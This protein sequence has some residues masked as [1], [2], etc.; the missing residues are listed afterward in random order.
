M[1]LPDKECHAN[2]SPTQ[3]CWASVMTLERTC[4]KRSSARK[5]E[6]G[7]ADDQQSMMYFPTSICC[8]QFKMHGRFLMSDECHKNTANLKACIKTPLI[9][10][11]AKLGELSTT[12][13]PECLSGWL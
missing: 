5:H 12:P 8:V 3:V 1:L 13:R 2:F 6:S 9:Q 4:L 11:L 10:L 7:A